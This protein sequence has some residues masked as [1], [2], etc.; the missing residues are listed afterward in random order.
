[1]SLVFISLRASA[2]PMP[3]SRM[4]SM[5]GWSSDQDRRVR[6]RRSGLYSTR[7]RECQRA[8]QIPQ[9]GCRVSAFGNDH[10]GDPSRE[11]E[12]FFSGGCD[13]WF[14]GTSDR[15]KINCRGRILDPLQIFGKSW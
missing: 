9:A 12:P 5:I 15:A 11:V 3:L 2:W 1:M 14:W 10:F 7:F 6:R 13:V 4:G 8:P